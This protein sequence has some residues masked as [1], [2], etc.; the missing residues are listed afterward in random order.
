MPLRFSFRQLEY[1]VA[2]GEAGTIALAAQRVN[3]SSPSISSAIS[4]LEAD[5]GL[6]LFVRHHAQGLSLTPGGRQ[7]FNEA[8]KI[9]FSANGLNNLAND[10]VEKARGPI[11]IGTLS[12]IAPIV[13]A[14]LRRAFEAAYPEASV[15]MKEGSQADLL[16]MLGQAEIDLAITYDLE[17]PK[18]IQ[19]EALASLPPQVMLASDHPKAQQTALSLAELEDENMILLDLPLSRE[20]FLSL[21]RECGL[22]PNITERTSD[23]SM[24]RSLVANGYGFGLVNLRIASERAPDGETLVTRP[25]TGALRPLDLGLAT[26]GTVR[27]SG[28]VAAF[29]DHAKAHLHDIGL[30]RLGPA[31]QR[32]RRPD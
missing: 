27:R 20:Y 30:M 4:Q 23:M 13:S 21:F 29:F 15:T 2:V 8:K 19:F 25:L 18:D 1:L 5:L 9:L 14:R 12:T 16:R 7:V 24:V 11:T 31:P 17:I 32:D 10:I 22:R 26:K 6:Q 28:V 3:V